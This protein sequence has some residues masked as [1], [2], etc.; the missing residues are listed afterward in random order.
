MLACEHGHV[1]SPQPSLPARTRCAPPSL[2]LPRPAP[3]PPPTPPRPTPPRR[4]RPRT[5]FPS[6]RRNELDNEGHCA[7]E[8]AT[9]GPPRAAAAL[10]DHAVQAELV[11]GVVGGDREPDLSYLSHPVRYDGDDKLLDTE[12]DAV[13]MDWEAPLM[14]RH[15]QVMCA[16]RGD[17]MNIGFG[18]GIIDGYVQDENSPRSHTI[19]EA[20]PDVYA[21]MKR[22]GWTSKPNVHVEFGRW[23]D[24]LRDI[25]AANEKLPGG[26]SNP[27]A[28][29]FDGV[30]HDTYGEGVRRH[31]RAA[32][33]L[34][35]DPSA[36][37]GVLVFQRSRAG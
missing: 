32:R 36:R 20:H 7:G 21:H 2:P 3:P 13:M 23:Q 9:A 10:I 35:R 30:F 4:P 25:I 1:T 26:R 24:V 31:A 28:R 18:M 27:K 8:W 17:V 19:V 22:Q 16:S 34:A 37:R 11:L 33:V 29:L 6:S 5:P 15:A 14:R 12:N